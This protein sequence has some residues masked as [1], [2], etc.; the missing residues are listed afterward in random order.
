MN[1]VPDHE[2]VH[3]HV[4]DHV[5]EVAPDQEVDPGDQDPAQ[6]V[7]QDLAQDDP[8]Q[9]VVQGAAQGVDQEVAHVVARPE[10]IHDLV[11]GLDLEADPAH[12]LQNETDVQDLVPEVEVARNQEADRNRLRL[13]KVRCWRLVTLGWR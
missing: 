12:E 10:R 8:D 9:E 7:D 1:Q 5:A 4:V 2:V 11:P 3:V 6:E 13:N